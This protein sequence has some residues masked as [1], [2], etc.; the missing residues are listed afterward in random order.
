MRCGRNRRIDCHH[1]FGTNGLWHDVYFAERDRQCSRISSYRYHCVLGLRPGVRIDLLIINGRKNSRIFKRLTHTG[2]ELQSSLHST[3]SGDSAF[4]RK[5]WYHIMFFKGLNN[6]WRFDFQSL[7]CTR[8]VLV[9]LTQ[10]EE[11]YGLCDMNR[12]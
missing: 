1:F 7:N 5:W 9:D 3:T 8:Q 10:A 4:T 6:C 11:C 12:C 2:T